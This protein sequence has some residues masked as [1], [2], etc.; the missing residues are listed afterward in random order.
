MRRSTRAASR[1]WPSEPASTRW[2]CTS[3][4]A[5]PSACNCRK[6]CALSASPTSRST[7]FS[8]DCVPATSR[9]TN[10]FSASVCPISCGVAA[11]SLIQV[12]PENCATSMKATS[13]RLAVASWCNLKAVSAST[14]CAR[15]RPRPAICRRIRQRPISSRSSTRICAAIRSTCQAPRTA[16]CL[17]CATCL[18]RSTSFCATT[19]STLTR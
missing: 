17:G 13:A 14:T 10:K 19:T 16:T 11:A 7:R 8:T 18:G 3:A 1:R 15:P 2:R 4:M 5:C 9:P 12:S 6:S